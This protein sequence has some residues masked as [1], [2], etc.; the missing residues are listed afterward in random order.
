[1][2]MTTNA[3]ESIFAAQQELVTRL[4]EFGWDLIICDAFVWA[5]TSLPLVPA[6]GLPVVRLAPVDLIG[7]IE[8]GAAA[9]VGAGA[10]IR[11]WAR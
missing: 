11:Q 1:M 7:L 6:R 9:P 3:A 2:S 4:D 8:R 5:C 10:G